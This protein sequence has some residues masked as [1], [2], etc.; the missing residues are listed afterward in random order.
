MRTTPLHRHGP[1]R[2]GT[3]LWPAV[4]ANL[5]LPVGARE[6]P[7]PSPRKRKTGRCE[8]EIC[9]FTFTRLSGASDYFPICGVRG[10]LGGFITTTWKHRRSPE[11]RIEIHRRG[12]GRTRLAATR[13]NEIVDGASTTLFCTENAGR[14]DLWVRGTRVPLTCPTLNWRRV[15]R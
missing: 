13:W 14:P 12:L 8:W 7:T 1:L 5:G 3:P 11:V 15:Y 2:R 6:T 4:I 10:N 9:S